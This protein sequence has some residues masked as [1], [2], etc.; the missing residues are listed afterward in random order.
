MVKQFVRNFTIG[1]WI[2][3]LIVLIVETISLSLMRDQRDYWQKQALS[4]S[5]DSLLSN[6][7][8]A[9]VEVAKGEIKWVT[10]DTLGVGE[11]YVPPEGKA[12]ITVP[13]EIKIDTIPVEK[14]SLAVETTYVILPPVISLKEKGFSSSPL[15]GINSDLS[16]FAGIKFFYWKRWGAVAGLSLNL[17][18]DRPGKFLNDVA[19]GISFN[20]PKM[21]SLFG[22][23]YEPLHKQVVLQWL[24]YF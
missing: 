22:L 8:E 12:V 20:P 14:E 17:T 11:K 4:Q 5:V 9:E 3:L 19:F 7:E 13:R 18:A 23:G 6:E 2:V 21:R 24:F 16:F 15:V 10:R 1:G